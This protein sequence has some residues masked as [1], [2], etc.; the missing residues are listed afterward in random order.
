MNHSKTLTEKPE[1]RIV[2]DTS[3]IKTDSENYLL[4][5]EVADIVQDSS[6]HKN[7]EIKWFLPEM[8]ILERRFQMRKEV[9]KVT[10][11]SNIKKLEKFFDRKLNITEEAIDNRIKEIVDGEIKK[12]G[13]SVLPLKVNDVNWNQVIFDAAFRKAPFEL[14]EKEKG[15]RDAVICETVCQLASSSDVTTVMVVGDGLLKQAIE[16]RRS[17]IR[18]LQ[19]KGSID[20]LNS[21]INTLASEWKEEFILEIQKNAT[22]LFFQQ[23]DKDSIFY[24]ENIRSQIE[25]K[26]KQ[27][28]EAFPKGANYIAK[29]TW[30]VQPAIF[31]RKEGDKVHWANR[32]QIQSMAYKTIVYFESPTLSD[33]LN[34]PNISVIDTSTGNYLHEYKKDVFVAGEPKSEEKLVWGFLQPKEREELIAIGWAN[35]KVF[36]SVLVNNKNELTSPQLEEDIKFIGTV[37]MEK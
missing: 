20:E 5:K 14:S 8:V 37:W 12:L 3:I 6:R 18:N 9:T 16:L 13:I 31:L 15:F 19:V 28:L 27:E 25:A 30:E 23:D 4:R 32:I 7:L 21:L 35:F 1:I 24:R 22:K 11:I 26:F 2:F 17:K 10:P 29:G 36:W 34:K 33:L